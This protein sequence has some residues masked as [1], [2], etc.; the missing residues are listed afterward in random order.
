LFG[1]DDHQGGCLGTIG[2]YLG[3]PDQVM[4]DW[5]AVHYGMTS[6]TSPGYRGQC[7]AFFSH[8]FAG[9][10]GSFFWATNSPVMRETWWT[11]QRTS[12]R[13]NTTNNAIEPVPVRRERT[14]D[15]LDPETGDLEQIIVNDMF[16][17]GPNSN[18]AHIIYEC[19]VDDDFGLGMDATDIDVGSFETAAAILYAEKLGLSMQWTQQTTIESFIRDVEHHIDGKLFLNPQTGLMTLRLVRKPTSYDGLFE[20]NPDNANVKSFHRKA[21]SE[22][23]S[24]VIVTWTNPWNEEAETVVVQNLAAINLAGQTVPSSA[25]YYAARDPQTGAMLG[26]RDLRVASYP[27]AGM[28]VEV[29][30]TAW[31]IVP[32]D[33]VRVT[34]PEYGIDGVYFRVLK[35]DYGRP[36]DSKITLSMLE[37]VFSFDVSEY[38]FG[39][40]YFAGGETIEAPRE[41]MFQRGFTIPA[42]FLVSSERLDGLDISQAYIGVLAS[43]PSKQNLSAYL[44][45]QTVSSNGD[46]A[47]TNVGQIAVLGRSYLPPLDA[48]ATSTLTSIGP[49]TGGQPP[50]NAWFGVIGDVGDDEHEIV[51][52]QHIDPNGGDPI[53]YLARGCFDTVPRSW[54]D[55]TPCFWFGSIAT[56]AAERRKTIGATVS[57]KLQSRTPAGLLD[58]D[59]APTF[60]VVVSER[61]HLPNRPANVLANGKGLGQDWVLVA[62]PPGGS[63]PFVPA[64]PGSPIDALP[65]VDGLPLYSYVEGEDLELTWARRNRISENG[66]VLMWA[67]GDVTPEVGQTTTVR[68]ETLAGDLIDEWVGITGTSHTIA[69]SVLS[70]LGQCRLII[71]SARDG[72]PSLQSVVMRLDGGL[73]H[74]T[75]DSTS[76]SFDLETLTWDMLDG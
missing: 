53:Y 29:D 14:A 76:I 12:K 20:I 11:V 68:L 74:P 56:I 2:V 57:L 8:F 30:R 13:L 61:P 59:A 65:L 16:V 70:T 62:A 17:A 73:A 49:L 38:S 51:M 32:T 18:G 71:S 35:V 25:N 26:A 19:L 64:A 67:D 42:Y 23:V 28:D 41:M 43:Q 39:P 22:I 44:N 50:Q 34:W 55:H 31:A 1:G 7:T 15:I 54:P 3:G 45:E 47:W 40:T 10:P 5:W 21:L 52:M 66:R 60:T 37:D 63:N 69:D 58:I 75:F 9:L 36:G 72:E 33:V 46:T 24:E 27:L 48:K 6:E 4:P